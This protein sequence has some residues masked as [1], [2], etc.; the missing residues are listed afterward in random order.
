MWIQKQSNTDNTGNMDKIQ[1]ADFLRSLANKY[2]IRISLTHFKQA[3]KHFIIVFFQKLFACASCVV[4]CI[5]IK[6]GLQHAIMHT[7]TPTKKR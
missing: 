6:K 1:R 2:L 5:C 4:G 7:A 3:P